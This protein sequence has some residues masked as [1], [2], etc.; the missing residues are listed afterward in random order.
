LTPGTRVALEFDA[1]RKAV[2]E[3]RA[4]PFT[5]TVKPKKNQ[6]AVNQPFEVELRVVNASPSPQSFRVMNCSWDEHWRSSNARVTWVGWDCS[7]NSPVT[8]KLAPGEAYAKTLSM[9]VT[10][11]GPVSF[12]LGFTP[13]ESKR[14]SWS[15]E[16]T[17]ELPQ[18][19]AVAEEEV[20]RGIMGPADLPP[21]LG[22]H[23]DL[24]VDPLVDREVR[25]E[26]CGARRIDQRRRADLGLAERCGRGPGVW[27]ADLLQAVG[28][29][30]P[31]QACR[32]LLQHRLQLGHRLG[33]VDAAEEQYR[34]MAA[35][36]CVAVGG[37]EEC[38]QRVGSADPA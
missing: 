20:V 27:S 35:H 1:D 29:G 31:H 19:A 14:T 15:N 18:A 37:R 30:R 12:K 5:V 13:L 32:I 4:E 23:G 38:A 8:V 26:A 33:A 25:A 17:L 24:E 11:A 2:L 21:A 6:V 9:L 22:L 3:I 10:A 16:V 28:R 36:I 34:G 7:K